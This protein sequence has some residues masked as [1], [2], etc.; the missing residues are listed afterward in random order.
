[1]SIFHRRS[2]APPGFET[3]V[4]LRRRSLTR[5][6][7]PYTSGCRSDWSG[8]FEGSTKAVFSALTEYGAYTLGSCQRYCLVA[9]AV[10][11]C[12]CLYADWDDL[13]VVRDQRGVNV[14]YCRLSGEEPK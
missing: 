2:A 13:S 10:E 12:G 11:E 3:S 14:S 9:V 1:M 7:S 6:P 5:L 4:S 8:V